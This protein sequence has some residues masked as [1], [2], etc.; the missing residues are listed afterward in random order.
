MVEEETKEEAIKK[1]MLSLD[2]VM[3][4]NLPPEAR[5]IL[6]RM[7]T[8][9]E[10][11]FRLHPDR[12]AVFEVSM[13]SLDKLDGIPG[14]YDVT[15]GTPESLDQGLS[16]RAEFTKQGL[17]FVDRFNVQI[18]VLPVDEWRMEW[19]IVTKQEW[20]ESRSPESGMALMGSNAGIAALMR[21]A[22]DN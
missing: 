2:Q 22:G 10:D 11:N 17:R 19:V 15:T 20:E 6:E 16:E 21:R 14:F 3:R 18:N 7:D 4:L 12:V 5:V 1:P 8:E 9:H 13:V